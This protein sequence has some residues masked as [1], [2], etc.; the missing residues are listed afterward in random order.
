MIE[1]DEQMRAT[2][3]ALGHLYRALASLRRDLL[4]ASPRQ[5]SLFAE[6]PL[7]QIR[8][9]QSEIDQYLGL[10]HAAAEHADALREQAAPYDPPDS[11]T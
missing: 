7:E 1:N 6:G 10:E 5:Y 8:K 2:H 4:P 9:L 11:G 3:E